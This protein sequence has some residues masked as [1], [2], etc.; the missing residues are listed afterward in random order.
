MGKRDIHAIALMSGGLDSTLAAKMVLD[1]GVRVT[2]LHLASPFGCLNDVRKNAET[3][4][5]PLI[6]KDKGEAYLD[7]VKS[8]KYGYGKNMNPCVDC[9]VFM[10]Q[11]GEKILEEEKAQF[12][13]TGE[14]LGQRPMSQTRSSINIIDSDSQMEGR[15]LRPLCAQLFKPTLAEQEG[16]VDRSQFM[17]INGRGRKEQIALAEK[18]GIGNFEAPGG[19]CLLTEAHFSDRLRDFF[20]HDDKTARL[21]RSALLRYGRHYRLS[22]KVRLIVGRNEEE[23]RVLEASWEKVQGSFFKPKSFGGAVAVA[24][25]DLG[26]EER[27]LVGRMLVRYGKGGDGGTVELRS[28]EGVSTFEV[29]GPIEEAKLIEMRI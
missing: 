25:G 23:N 28:Q 1:Q 20:R 27:T 5:V 10:F 2:G 8:P 26:I 17:R 3:I 29:A 24:F 18:W 15:V 11:L 22:E 6:I 16:W 19:G 13:I 7:L 14:V 21:E 4:G 9:R 12:L